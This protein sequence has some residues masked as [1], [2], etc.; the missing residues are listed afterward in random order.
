MLNA[1]LKRLGVNELGAGQDFTLNSISVS[2]LII[3]SVAVGALCQLAL[4]RSLGAM[5]Y[6]RYAIIISWCLFFSA[7]TMAGLDGSIIRFASAYFS[8]GQGEQLRTFTRVIALLQIVAVAIVGTV[9]LLTPLGNMALAGLGRQNLVWVV[10]Y[11]GSTAFLGSFSVFFA[12]FRYYFFAQFYQNFLRSAL[13]IAGI[14]AASASLR[15]ALDAQFALML[16]SLTSLVALILLL[17]HLLRTMLKIGEGDRPMPIIDIKRWL[18]FSGWVQIGTI[19]QQVTSQAPIILI[20]L[21]A[22]P[23]DAGCY[24]IA[25]RLSVLVTVGLSA[26]GSTASPI[27]SAAHT[28]GDKAEIARIA[29]LAA[30]LGTLVSIVAIGFFAF[31]GTQVIG[32]F[33]QGFAKAYAPL[34]MLLLGAF[35]NAFTGVNA[36][37]LAM[38]DRPRFVVGA[39]VLGMM[40]NIVVSYLLIP[41]LGT[42]GAATGT[43]TGIL[44][45]NALMA[46]QVYLKLG[47]DS[48]AIGWRLREAQSEA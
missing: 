6:G 26:V 43:V 25:S 19:C 40:V 1:F 7:P 10:V 2:A 9:L 29:R 34:M 30:R 13:L 32:L 5:E 8:H 46:Y 39:L 37:L 16:T 3:G 11:V 23:S 20:G 17:V 4:T 36:I 18:R 12:A 47:I 31:A 14:L 33:G 35:F 38:T 45:S 44:M 42:L 48:T 15:P 41:M 21:L 24:A 22:T 28:R 27:I